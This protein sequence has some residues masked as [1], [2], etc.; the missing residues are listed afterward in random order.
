M[1]N[2]CTSCNCNKDGNE[3]QELLTVDNKYGKVNLN[4]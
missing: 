3:A 4:S 1:G 2:T